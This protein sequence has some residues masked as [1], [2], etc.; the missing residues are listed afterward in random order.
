MHFISSSTKRH[1]Q[2]EA[3]TREQGQQ[4]TF[5]R[6]TIAFGLFFLI[7][8]FSVSKIQA[9]EP[10]KILSFGDSLS[11]G[12]QLPSGAGF[13][14]QLQKRLNEEP[15]AVEVINAAVSGD[16][17]AAGLARLDWS[18]PDG[19]DIVLLE[20]GANDALQGLPV[21]R[22]KANL[23]EMIEKFQ[24]RNIT[25][26]LIGMQAPPNMGA[27]YVEAFNAIF[28]ALAKQYSVPF[29][30]F[31]LDGV[32]AI[33]DLNLSDGMHPNEEGIKIIVKKIAPFVIDIV[34][35]LN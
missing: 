22:A 18:T 7:A 11:A 2:A 10:I 35:T 5:L 26:G 9:A 8:L 1:S 6:I 29:Y 31:F 19:V 33:T 25:V 28:P 12:Y 4:Q 21:D 16:T 27:D 24:S 20:L 30:P 3:V 17:T 15:H 14:D 32:A 23:A 13:T 34:K